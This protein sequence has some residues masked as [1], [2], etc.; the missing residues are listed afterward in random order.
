[1]TEP[2]TTLPDFTP[3]PRS[4]DRSNGWKPEVQRAFIEALADTGSVSDACRRV[5]RTTVGAYHLRRHPEAGEFRAA[6][7]AAL[8]LGMRRLEDALTERAIHGTAVPVFCFGNLIGHRTVFNDRLGMF[9][10]R[11]RLPQRYGA[12]GGA[13]G[14]SG[15]DKQRLKRLKKQWREEWQRERDEERGTFDGDA[16]IE[17]LEQMHRRWYA[18]LSRRTRAAYREFRRIERDDREAGYVPYG[19][20][21]AEAEAEYDAGAAA[22][23]GRAKINF[24]IEADGYGVDEVLAEDEQAGEKPETA[25]PANDDSPAEPASSAEPPTPEQPAPE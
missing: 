25:E 11:N 2:H 9:M 16:L 12:G 22:L 10:L 15:L 13:K 14:L 1:M 19:E 8:D 23:G 18:A 21:V 20:E 17:K 6:W 24:M 7:E 4:K 5:G 3:V